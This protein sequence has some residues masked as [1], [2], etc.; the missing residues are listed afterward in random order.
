[1]TPNQAAEKV[2]TYVCKGCGAL[3]TVQ[4]NGHESGHVRP[5]RP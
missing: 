4:R 1:M 5:E 2:T 3:I